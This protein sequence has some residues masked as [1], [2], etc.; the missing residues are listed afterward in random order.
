VPILKTTIYLYPPI[1]ESMMQKR[2]IIIVSGDVQ[3]VG[4]RDIV[5]KIARKMKITGFVENIKPYDVR[6]VCEGSEENI[7]F[8]IDKL[9][10]KK[11]PVEV[12]GIKFDFIEPSG[13]FEIFEVKRGDIAEELGE[14]L[15]VA[16]LEMTKMVEKQDSA[17]SKQDSMLEKQ[18]SALSKQDSML[19][20]QDSALSKQDSMLDLQRKTIDT[21]KLEGEKTRDTIS[22]HISNDL[23]DLRQEI[24]HMKSILSKVM[25]KIGISE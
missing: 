20:K 24:I 8:F 19:E 17:L 13:E 11:F 6:I 14:R 2:A 25:D 10:I 9:N 3:G 5:N 7:S 4:Y 23:A 21:I 22:I 18:D 16:R 12:E 15:D 1:H